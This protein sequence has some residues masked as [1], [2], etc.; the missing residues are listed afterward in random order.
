MNFKRLFIFNL[1]FVIIFINSCISIRLKVG[2]DFTYLYN[3]KLT[4]I[5]SLLNV[6]GYYIIENNKVVI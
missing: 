5:D 2:D 4:G 6:D 1:F 3:G